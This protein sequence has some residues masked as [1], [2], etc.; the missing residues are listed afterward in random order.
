MTFAYPDGVSGPDRGAVAAGAAI[1]S[2]AKILFAYR[3]APFWL[4]RH[5]MGDTAFAPAFDVLRRRGVAF[6]WM[7]TLE[8][9]VPS[10]DGAV[11]ALEF[12]ATPLPDNPML[13]DLDGLQAW[14]SAPLVRPETSR[15]IRLERANDFDVVILAVPAPALHDPLAAMALQHPHLRGALRTSASV[16]TRAAQVWSDASPRL[17]GITTGF[18]DGYPTAADL[19][20]V[21]QSERWTGARRPTALTYLVDTTPDGDV[22]AAHRAADRWVQAAGIASAER[23]RYVRVNV[24]PADRYV[25]TLPG[26]VRERL[27]PEDD[28]I[29]GLR[30][31]GDWTSTSINGGSVEAAFESGERAAASL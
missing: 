7:H 12:S 21:L 20:E 6:S 27:T 15:S 16:G 18:G 26:T 9:V 14:P 11:A 24:E 3:G 22:N 28:R 13:L 25:L 31:A 4:L 2:M 17:A 23:E 5:G 30:F 19:S 29:A 1:R 10:A 8:A